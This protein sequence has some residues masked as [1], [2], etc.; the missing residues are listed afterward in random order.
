MKRSAIVLAL[1]FLPTLANANLVVNGSFESDIQAAG[2][3][4]IYDNLTGWTGGRTGIELRNNVSGAASDGVNFVELDTTRNS[5]M[6]QI[7]STSADTWYTLSFDYS[8]REG[9][10]SESNQIKVFWNHDLLTSPPLK[11]D[12][13]P[14]GSG[15]NWATYSFKVLG[16]GSDKLFFDALGTNDSYGGSLDNVNVSAVPEPETYG[17]MLAGLGLMGL[18]ARRRKNN[19]A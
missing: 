16:T 15:N 4:N 9:I 12:G 17:M 6:Y 11:G 2:T 8:P 5:S 19:Q 3:W 1:A 13:G 18:M 10:P 14:L 7:V